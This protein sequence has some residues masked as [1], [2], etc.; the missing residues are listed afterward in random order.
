M[1]ELLRSAPISLLRLKQAS[2]NIARFGIVIGSV[3]TLGLL[4]TPTPIYMFMVVLTA[5]SVPALLLLEPLESN[6]RYWSLYMLGFVLFA[7]FRGFADDTFIPVRFQYV[8]D[9]DMAMF[10]GHLPTTWLQERFYTGQQAPLETFA[11]LIHGSYFIIPHLFALLIWRFRPKD[12]K[13]YALAALGIFT[14]GLVLYFLLPT[15]PPWMA[16]RLGLTA[17]MERILENLNLFQRYDVFSRI[18]VLVGDPNLVGAMPSLHL[19]LTAL[20][21]FAMQRIDRRL[22]IAGWVY[23]LLMAFSL[24]YLGEHYVIDLLV[25]LLVAAVAWRVATRATLNSMR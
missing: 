19:A 5:F 14:L 22:G 25:G 4:T 1:Q 18:Y 10:G 8:I 6:Y 7:H 13:P 9:L 23:T 17:P 20:G 11:F 16:S 3:I 12:L 21:A 2:L 15:A 24:V